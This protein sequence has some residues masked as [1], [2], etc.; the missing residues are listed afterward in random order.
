[1]E[2]VKY[3]KKEVVEGKHAVP[4][5]NT[6]LQYLLTLFGDQAEATA[7]LTWRDACFLQGQCSAMTDGLAPHPH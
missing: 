1:M 3:L 4:C 2:L 7:L 5:A 6:G